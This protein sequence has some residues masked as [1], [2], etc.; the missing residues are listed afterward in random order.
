MVFKSKLF[1][2]SK[3]DY[4]FLYMYMHKKFLE[5]Y[6]LTCKQ[7]M[8]LGHRMKNIGK[9]KI[10]FMFLYISVF[11]VFFFNENALIL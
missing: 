9:G 3:L 2:V 4:S 10:F 5:A 11:S 1:N 6:T 8:P 7:R